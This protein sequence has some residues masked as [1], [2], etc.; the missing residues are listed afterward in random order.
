MAGRGPYEDVVEEMEIFI[1]GATP[2][3]KLAEIRQ[4]MDTAD[5]ANRGDKASTVWITYQPLNTSPALFALILGDAEIILPGNYDL[6]NATQALDPVILR[7]R[8]RGLWTALALDTATSG[9]VAHP[10]AASITGLTATDADSLL[11]V[12][13]GA[14]DEFGSWDHPWYIL[15]SIAAT[16]LVLLEAEDMGT[17]APYTVVADTSADAVGGEVLRYTPAGT[18]TINSGVITGFSI[19]DTAAR[20]GVYINYRNN[21]TTTSYR[22]TVELCGE[23][24]PE[25]V[26]PASP[27]TPSLPRWIFAG[28]VGV[29][30]AATETLRIWLTASAASGTVDFDSVV[31]LA[32]DDPSASQAI[33]IVAGRGKAAGA[34]NFRIDHNYRTSKPSQ[35]YRNTTGLDLSYTGDPIFILPASVSAV[36]FMVLATDGTQWVPC[37]NAGTPYSTT[38]AVSQDGGYL[39]PE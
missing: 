32:M 19:S 35:V 23:E 28:F 27:V 18:T 15:K 20:W 22:M 30:L 6:S 3:A 8:R 5:K 21:S 14:M 11:N 4:L 17:G 24:T 7:F 39:I 25:V 13:I 31:L 36:R 26:I 29:P 16:D 33:E 12:T 38:I 10:V 1:G 2:M 37:T 9:A 34:G